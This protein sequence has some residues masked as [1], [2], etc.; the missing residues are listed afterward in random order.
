M[1]RLAIDI[2]ETTGWSLWEDGEKLD[3]GQM[4]GR[5]FVDALA[6]AWG[7]G[8]VENCDHAFNGIDVVIIEDWVLYPWKC[9]ELAMDPLETV[10]LLGIVE[11]HAMHAEIPLIYQ[12]ADVGKRRDLAGDEYVTPEH[13]NRHENDSVSHGAW[14]WIQRRLGKR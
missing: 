6:W 3:G 7:V 4:N 8:Y 12:G 9:E 14:D 5:E 13:P 10:R 11:D 1:R 2:G